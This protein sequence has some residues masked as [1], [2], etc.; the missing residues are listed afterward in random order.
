M[1]LKDE[2]PRRVRRGSHE[3]GRRLV[4]EFPRGGEGEALA[5]APSV[6]VRSSPAERIMS[7]NA[8]DAAFASR[9]S[10]S[11]VRAP[12]L[13]RKMNISVSIRTSLFL[14]NTSIEPK[15]I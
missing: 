7:R 8:S 3:S 2:R 15:S 10:S 4:C 11:T 9:Q 1:E 13:S 12:V 14:P 6:G 5:L